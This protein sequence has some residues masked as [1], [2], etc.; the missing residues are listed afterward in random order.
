MTKDADQAA[1][2]VAIQALLAAYN[3]AGDRGALDALLAVFAGDGVLEM[4]SGAF[5]G[6]DAIETFLSGVA[7]G[8]AEIDLRGSRHHLTT[9]HID[10]VSPTAALGWTYFFVMRA[11]VVI[12]EG[13][14][15]D[16]FE[17]GADGWRI[18]HRRVKIIWTRAD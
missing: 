17:C 6:R 4:P 15:V 14:Y 1:A 10:L 3:A 12:Q 8:G 5:H 2:R 9:S 16:R 7:A 13:T 18:A 11:G